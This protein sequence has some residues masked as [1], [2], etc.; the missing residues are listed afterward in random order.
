MTIRPAYVGGLIVGGAAGIMT[1]SVGGVLGGIVA[2]LI[3]G[4][5]FDFIGRHGP[6]RR[7]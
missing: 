2:G 1:L 4:A 3:L 7:P 5:I 6:L